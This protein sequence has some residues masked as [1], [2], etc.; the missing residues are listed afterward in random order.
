MSGK[1]EQKGREGETI[2]EFRYCRCGQ[3]FSVEK[4]NIRNVCYSCEIGGK[5]NGF[6]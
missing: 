3:K 1:D 2:W 5:E 4:Y 6:R